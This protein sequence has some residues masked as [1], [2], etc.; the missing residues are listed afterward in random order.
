V[1][2]SRY[3]LMEK[4]LNRLR[5]YASRI[6]GPCELL[7]DSSWRHHMSAVLRLR[8]ASGAEWF[9]K[10]HR[11]R[12]RYD[13]ELMAYRTWV[14]ALKGRAPQ[15]RAFD[16]S[17]QAVILSALPGQPA[18]WPAAEPGQPD[19]ERV[20]ERAIQRE[21][22]VILRRLHDAQAAAPW[23]GF[24]ADKM[25]QFNGLAAAVAGLL[26]PGQLAAARA[27]IARLTSIPAP[28]RVPCH[29]DYT[30]RNWQVHGGAVYVFDF[31]W[32]G[33]DAWVADLARLHL[34]IWPTRPDLQEAFLQGYGR[35][36]GPVEQLA[37]HGCAVLTGVW[38][39]SKARETGQPS[40]EQASR[41]AL[42]RLIDR[43]PRTP[44]HAHRG[45]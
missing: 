15:L 41:E 29:H 18:S 31:E 25:E 7:E 34:G 42:L 6:L 10:C 16:E 45:D 37:L 28:A 19:A 8:D 33:P 36:L 13:A 43:A 24:A 44:H 20:R 23:P 32:S 14:A 1:T 5:G 35:H 17:L 27:E 12:E 40:F 21:A 26:T 38:L 39:V 3:V 11:D 22:G 4:P 9:L 2:L 30:P